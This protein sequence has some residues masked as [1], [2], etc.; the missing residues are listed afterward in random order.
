[1]QTHT[2]IC[3]CGHS[4]TSLMAAMFASHAEVFIPLRETEAFLARD[5]VAERLAALLAEA[6]ASGRPHLAEKTPRHVRRIAM[7]RRRV[8]GA[9]FVAMVRDG[10]DVAASFIRRLG[11]AEPG[12]RRWIADNTAL[13]RE[14]DAPDVMVVRY[15][16]LIEAPEAV[17]RRVCAFAGSGSMR[18]CCT[19]TRRR[20]SGSTSPT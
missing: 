1:M 8:P 11:A 18:G 5:A 15:E 4:G 10:R 14:Q 17:L 7:I 6:R 20:A 19:T 16:D 13:G 3:G 12:A 9:R 2:F